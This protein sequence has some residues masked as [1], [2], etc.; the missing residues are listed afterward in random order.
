MLERDDHFPSD[1][2]L[3]GEMDAIARAIAMGRERRLARV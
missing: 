3:G 1:A 2:M